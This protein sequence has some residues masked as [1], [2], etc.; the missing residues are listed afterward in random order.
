MQDIQQQMDHV[1]TFDNV[2]SQSKISSITAHNYALNV[3]TQ[4]LFGVKQQHLA[5]SFFSLRYL[6]KDAFDATKVCIPTDTMTSNIT[7]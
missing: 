1:L 5:G 7:A 2:A 6:L 4:R 3:S